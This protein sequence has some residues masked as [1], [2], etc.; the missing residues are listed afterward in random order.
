MTA[1]MNPF[2]DSESISHL[3]MKKHAEQGF[4]QMQIS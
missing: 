3:S 2:S 4:S 1:L